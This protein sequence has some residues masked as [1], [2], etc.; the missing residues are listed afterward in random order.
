MITPTDYTTWADHHPEVAENFAAKPLPWPCQQITTDLAFCH[1]PTIVKGP[2][3][4]LV[5]HGA[6]FGGTD[7][8]LWRSIDGGL[9]WQQHASAPLM[10]PPAPEGVTQI[11][12]AALGVGATATGTLLIACRQFA[13]AGTGD[14]FRD[15]IHTDRTWIIRSVDGGRTWQNTGQLDPAPYDNI[16]GAKARIH[17]MCEGRL[18]YPINARP[19]A[20]PGREVAEHEMRERALLFESSDDGATWHRIASLGE[21]TDE[22]DLLELPSGRILASTRFQRR[23]LPEDPADL[24]CPLFLDE[25]GRASL[26]RH[27][28][29]DPYEV[30][31]HSVI[32]NTCILHSDD[33]GATWSEPRLVTGWLQQTAGLVR[34]SDGTVVMPYGHKDE[35]H[36]QRFVLSYDEGETWSN[37][38]FELNR[39]GMYAHSVAL[40]DDT[41]VT[42]TETPRWHRPVRLHVLRWQ[43]PPRNVV[44]E[45]GFFRPRP[46]TPSST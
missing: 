28:D 8:L 2:D 40:D 34:L 36:G 22:S 27:G 18:L 26:E 16:G 42:V 5:T 39:F 15:P 46:V 30:G 1:Q 25:E 17:R 24:I 37:A 12:E 35:G 29:I 7:T 38:V 6:E 10:A 21:D 44:A 23:K 43:V 41:I 31:N 4:A 33:G 3:G 20:R 14:I 45:R 9:T 32:K 19:S 11:S 13:G